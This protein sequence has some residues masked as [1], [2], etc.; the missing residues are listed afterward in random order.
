MCE[1][2]SIGR[3]SEC[4]NQ[5]GGLTTT[6]LKH[7][8]KHNPQPTTTPA[9]A[10]L[11]WATA[12]ATLACS[13]SRTK[14]LTHQPANDEKER[15]R[16]HNKQT[17]QTHHKHKTPHTNPHTPPRATEPA[18]AAAKT[19]HSTTPNRPNRHTSQTHSLHSLGGVARHLPGYEAGDNYLLESSS[20][21]N[22]V[23]KPCGQVE[24]IHTPGDKPVDNF[25]LGGGPPVPQYRP[26]TG[27]HLLP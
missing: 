10:T 20:G 23:D 17:T 22:S 24:V 27:A 25:S 12:L 2:S 21:D 16:R 15:T 14:Q 8:D 5:T 4:G 19:A 3:E 26:T 18:R 11:S 6:P 13:Q 7:L 1:P 9:F